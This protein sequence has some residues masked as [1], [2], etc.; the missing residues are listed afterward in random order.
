MTA[1]T[2]AL[3]GSAAPPAAAQS[4][5]A[6]SGVRAALEHSSNPALSAA[7]SDAQLTAR[8]TASTNAE[9]SSAQGQTRAE[10]ELVLDASRQ[11]GRGDSSALGRLALNHQLAAERDTW[12][13]RLGYRRDRPL[14]RAGKAGD[15]AFGGGE[16]A[17]SE[18]ALGWSH[19]LHER[20]SLDVDASLGLTQISGEAAGQDYR[21]AA[22]SSGLSYRWSE[23]ATLTA[24]L[25][26]TRQQFSSDGL[27]TDIDSLRLR[28]SAT[29]S[30]RLSYQVS[31]ARSQTQQA[32]TLRH[33]VCPLPAGF[34]QGGLVPYV[35]AEQPLRLRR[36]LMQY[37]ASGSW[38]WR[39]TST[40]TASASRKLTPNTLGVS[41]DDAYA[42]S[43]S[44][45]LGPDTS[46]SL[47]LDA[48]R[49]RQ[50][51]LPSADGG[52]LVSL[53]LAASH[54]IGEGLSLQFQAQQRH[55]RR[56]TPDVGAS[57]S[58]ISISLQYLGATVPVWP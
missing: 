20:L 25:S 51:G 42:V 41:E 58:V 45:E 1:L 55:Y 21:V 13:A 39:E 24:S 4:W 37:D 49:S 8:V 19:A 32:F 43:L 57:G 56:G 15:I 6:Q 50:S 10:G 14:E 35:L 47:A 18:L 30:E 16:E 36:Q 34:C 12:S 48:S 7:G 44:H 26:R 11:D 22:G 33:L 3:C 52:R 27:R 38:R 40:L 31:V 5:T 23:T 17:V 9:R 28:W 54:R 53:T 46:A 2:A 29:P